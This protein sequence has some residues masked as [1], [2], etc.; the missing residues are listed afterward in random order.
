MEMQTHFKTSFVHILIDIKVSEWIH[1]NMTKKNT[2]VIAEG[3]NQ[4]VY[5]MLPGQS[6]L[7]RRQDAVGSGE[8]SSHADAAIAHVSGS[9]YIS[10]RHALVR[11]TED[12]RVLI[13]DLDSA[14][15]TYLRLPSFQEFELDENS[16]AM[17]AQDLVVQLSTT[18]WERLP[19]VGRLAT[20]ADFVGYLRTQLGEAVESIKVYPADSPEALQ[21]KG[22][23]LRQSLLA[24]GEY[25]IIK[26][27][28]T[29]NRAIERWVQ[30]CAAMFNSG[31]PREPMVGEETPWEFTAVSHDRRTVRQLARRVA[32]TSS[33][34]L[35]VGPTGTG[36][37]V[38]ARDIHR[39]SA[40]A[41]GPFIA[42]NCAAVPKELFE[43]ELF[44]AL[45]GSYTGCTNDR[46]GL[47]ERAAN[48]T[49]FLDEIG[50]LPFDLQAKLLRA[51]DT[52]RIRRVGESAEERPISARIV[53]AT[54]LD[55]ESMVAAG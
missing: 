11:Y 2:V 39:H 38:L 42:V 30:A 21:Q 13:K 50:D 55:L 47:F 48:G 18:R 54:N 12:G 5:S 24:T 41:K 27:Q 10:Q 3:K 37:D 23:H 6:L 52:R 46:M 20:A 26:W 19:D 40:R 51:L 15:G 22:P 25:L 4:S 31:A 32:L 34:V 33:T 17:L 49:L 14:N 53:A 1:G 9:P 28:H 35:L 16:Q 36:K 7:I 43:A 44:G 45:R 8:V 29:L